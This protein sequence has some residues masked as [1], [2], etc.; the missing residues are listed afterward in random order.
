MSS[1]GLS[2]RAG[3]ALAYS[4]WW[5]TGVILWI[6]ER[7]DPVV[8]FHAAQAVVVFGCAAALTALFGALALA[9]L[10]F[11]PSTFGFFVTA[12][13]V[14]WMAGVVVWGIT[15]WKVASGDEWRLPVAA[16]LADRFATVSEP[17]SA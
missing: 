10:T 11:L 14:T 12:A 9:S 1:L 7:R 13:L 2:S 8:R 5:V 6:L 17:A 16:A 15:M 4:G 3:S